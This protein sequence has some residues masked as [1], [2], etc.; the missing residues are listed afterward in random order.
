MDSVSRK[1]FYLVAD[2]DI[3]IG[4]ADVKLTKL[5]KLRSGSF[6]DIGTANWI[7]STRGTVSGIHG[8]ITVTFCGKFLKRGN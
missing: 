5:P 3:H 7:R 4:S 2:V 8:K 6:L 1:P